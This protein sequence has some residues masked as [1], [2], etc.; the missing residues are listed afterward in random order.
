LFR[1]REKKIMFADEKGMELHEVS[2]LAPFYVC[3]NWK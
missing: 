3:D 1:P 2:E